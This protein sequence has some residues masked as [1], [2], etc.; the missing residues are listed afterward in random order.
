MVC[1]KS[2]QQQELLELSTS[3]NHKHSLNSNQVYL[4]NKLR[5]LRQVCL[6]PKPQPFKANV[7]KLQQCKHRQV[8]SIHNLKPLCSMHNNS[9]HN[10][11]VYSVANLVRKL[12]CLEDKH[13]NNNREVAFLAL[14]DYLVLIKNRLD[15]FLRKHHFNLKHAFMVNR[16]CKCNSHSRY[17]PTRI[18]TL[19]KFIK[20][21]ILS[22]SAL[23][24]CQKLLL[25]W[26]FK[27]NLT[28]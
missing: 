20:A 28:A 5:N 23:A 10:N 1:F 18:K 24:L 16:K 27:K 13:N 26:T 2:H 14:E 8:F 9:S 25:F 6:D 3:N 17:K 22:I 19:H 21:K 15:L 12:L 4:V 7:S 11:Q